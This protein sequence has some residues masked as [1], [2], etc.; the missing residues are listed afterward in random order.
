[1]PL[2]DFLDLC[3]SLYFF[4]SKTGISSVSNNVRHKRQYIKTSSIALTLAKTNSPNIFYTAKNFRGT[5][6]WDVYVEAN[7]SNQHFH[8]NTNIAFW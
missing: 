5:K 3:D 7:W 2:K 6:N 1:M 8:K 4:L